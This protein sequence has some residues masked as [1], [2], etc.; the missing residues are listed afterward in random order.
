MTKTMNLVDSTEIFSTP[1][2]TREP[3]KK[4]PQKKATTPPE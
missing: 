1:T 2:S 3:T 4:S